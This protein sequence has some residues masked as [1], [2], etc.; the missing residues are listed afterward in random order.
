MSEPTE[1]EKLLLRKFAG[2]S[3]SPLMDGVKEVI[4]EYREDCTIAITSHHQ[5]DDRV[6]MLRGAILACDEIQANFDELMER[7]E[8]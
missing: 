1:A 6:H 8:G 7:A 5:T 4:K 3:T 2:A